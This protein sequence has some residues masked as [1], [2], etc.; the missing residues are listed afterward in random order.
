MVKPLPCIFDA[1][2]NLRAE[3]ETLRQAAS[4]PRTPPT[5]L[6]SGTASICS[7]SCF[8]QSGLRLT[9][10]SALT[11][12]SRRLSKTTKRDSAEPPADP[13]PGFSLTSSERSHVTARAA[14]HPPTCLEENCR[15]RDRK[16]QS[17]SECSGKT[18][19]NP[20]T[21]RGFCVFL[22]TRLYQRRTGAAAVKSRQDN[23]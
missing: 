2:W 13:R 5:W 20:D 10:N 12:M 19:M 21:L 6:L 4:L 7:R 3:G 17:R 22:C 11:D 16:V 23:Q 18:E 15:G 14:D 9:F 1:A 8:S